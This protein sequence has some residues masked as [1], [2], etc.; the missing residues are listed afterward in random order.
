MSKVSLTLNI[1]LRI[2]MLL[3][4]DEIIIIDEH[5]SNGKRYI[6]HNVLDNSQLITPPVKLSQIINKCKS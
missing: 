3:D 1:K 6:L 2:R 5:L 4:D